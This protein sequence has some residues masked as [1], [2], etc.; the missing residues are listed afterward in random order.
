MPWQRE[1]NRI[2]DLWYNTESKEK[3]KNMVANWYERLEM[4]MMIFTRH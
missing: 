1:E 4:L 3:N 2:K